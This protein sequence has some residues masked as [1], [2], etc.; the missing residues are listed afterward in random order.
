MDKRTLTAAARNPGDLHPDS[1][2]TAHSENNAHI[3]DHTLFE[4][5][6]PHASRMFGILLSRKQCYSPTFADFDVATRY[7]SDVGTGD[8]V[9]KIGR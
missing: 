8:S 1:G 9:A 3:E 6:G 2:D 5:T 7:Y 4:A